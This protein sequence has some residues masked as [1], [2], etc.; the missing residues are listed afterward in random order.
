MAASLLIG[1][2]GAAL[3]PNGNG[4]SRSDRIMALA[5]AGLT[6]A[7]LCVG[8]VSH[9]VIRHAVQVTPPV[10]A[11][12]LMRRRPGLGKSAAIPILTFWL[13]LMI[14]IWLFLLDVVRLIAGHFTT[15]E[16]ALTLVIVIMCGLGLLSAARGGRSAG[17][18]SRIAI[19]TV[20]ACLQA[21][22]LVLSMQPWALVK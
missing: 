13:G 11:L 17:L 1:I 21:G 19:S 14:L 16:I 3:L 7:L 9:T 6:V 4:Q 15:T 5:L 18:A 12:I 22:A 10:C 8:V 2:A 20:F